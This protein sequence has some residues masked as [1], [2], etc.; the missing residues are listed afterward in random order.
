MCNAIGL[1]PDNKHAWLFGPINIVVISCCVSQ[2]RRSHLL[3]RG[4]RA[5]HWVKD[6][7]EF[8]TK[9]SKTSEIQDSEKSQL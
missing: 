4:A 7:R 9:N 5:F 3:C 1:V 8:R 6:I 2:Q